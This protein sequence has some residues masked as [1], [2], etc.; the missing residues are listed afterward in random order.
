MLS[1]PRSDIGYMTPAVGLAQAPDMPEI[2][3]YGVPFV[4][5]H[6]ES[7]DLLPTELC[8]AEP[9]ILS[10]SGI[11]IHHIVIQGPPRV[12][13]EVQLGV[14]RLDPIM[15][16]GRKIYSWPKVTMRQASWS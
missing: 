10:L 2:L 5:S 16:P 12:P 14:Y 11:L 1:L 4:V 9:G 6:G 3:R 13:Y 15:E 8:D 7:P